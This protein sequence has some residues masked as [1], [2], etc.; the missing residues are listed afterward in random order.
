LGFKG[1]RSIICVSS[2]AFK[3]KS[4]WADFLNVLLHHEGKHTEQEYYKPTTPLQYIAEFGTYTTENAQNELEAL[5]N[6]LANLCSD[7]SER[8]IAEIRQMITGNQRFLDK[9]RRQQ[10]FD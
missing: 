3:N 7:N 5:R 10:N 4:S 2:L 1:Q 6:Q 9:L 8:F